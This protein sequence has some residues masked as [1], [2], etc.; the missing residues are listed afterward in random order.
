MTI[1]RQFLGS[2]RFL[3]C[4][5]C[6][7]DWVNERYLEYVFPH[8]SFL[9]PAVFHILPWPWQTLLINHNTA[10]WTQMRLLS[11]YHRA[12]STHLALIEVGF[13][14]KLVISR[15][16]DSQSSCKFLKSIALLKESSNS[17]FFFFFALKVSF[18]SVL[19]KTH[20]TNIL[21]FWFFKSHADLPS[22]S[23]SNLDCNYDL[24]VACSETL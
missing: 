2:L 22:P 4:Q 18:S 3:L 16:D 5:S 21:I 19:K 6:R 12:P 9:C 20:S 15:L 8:M 13:Q 17:F 7:L 24:N 14:L 11:I 23:Y 10:G 1:G